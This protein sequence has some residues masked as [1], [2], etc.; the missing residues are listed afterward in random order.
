MWTKVL[1]SILFLVIGNVICFIRL[2][3]FGSFN[4]KEFKYFILV[5]NIGIVIFSIL[6][7]SGIIL[8]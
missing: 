7:I 6:Y 8:K 5:V 1:L 2:M 3:V 4:W